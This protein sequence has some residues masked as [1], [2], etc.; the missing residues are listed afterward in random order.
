[1]RDIQNR[2]RMVKR[3]AI[4]TETR[5]SL[6]STCRV[7]GACL[8]HP[9]DADVVLECA[10]YAAVDRAGVGT[11]STRPAQEPPAAGASRKLAGLCVNCDHR[12]KCTYEQPVGGVWHC[13]DYC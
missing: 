2:D 1:M 13:E 11:S 5:T 9:G 10:S 3:N 7:A 6:C 4:G 8:L 12:F